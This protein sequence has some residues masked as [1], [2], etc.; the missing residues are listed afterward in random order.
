[1]SEHSSKAPDKRTRDSLTRKTQG[2][3]GMS[4]DNTRDNVQAFR[5]MMGGGGVFKSNSKCPRSTTVG[6][7]FRGRHVHSQAG[8]QTKRKGHPSPNLFMKLQIIIINK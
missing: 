6:S 7:R 2:V 5:E 4:E 8:A 1:M 3:Y